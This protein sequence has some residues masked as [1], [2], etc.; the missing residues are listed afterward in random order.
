MARLEDKLDSIEH[1]WKA[2]DRRVR[3]VWGVYL[4]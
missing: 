1:D 4:I 2:Q 3:F